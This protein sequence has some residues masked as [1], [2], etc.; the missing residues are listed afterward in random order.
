MTAT[1]TTAARASAF[2]IESRR[3]RDVPRQRRA[4]VHADAPGK[5]LVY[6][7]APRVRRNRAVPAGTAATMR[8]A[9]STATRSPSS[10]TSATRTAAGTFAERWLDDAFNPNGF[11][12]V[13]I[14]ERAEQRGRRAQQQLRQHRRHAQRRADE[15][16]SR[17][18]PGRA[19][20][21]RRR[22]GR[23]CERHDPEHARRQRQRAGQHLHPAQRHAGVETRAT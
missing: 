16:R 9:G 7:N 22:S 14:Y 6:Q 11:S 2:V 8:W 17:H 20:R 4:R 21:Q 13:Y 23:R 19:D 3:R 12:N 1:R 15:L 10:S 5:T 18:A